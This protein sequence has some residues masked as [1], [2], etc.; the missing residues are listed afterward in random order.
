MVIDEHYGYFEGLFDWFVKKQGLSLHL[1]FVSDGDIAVTG[2]FI[3]SGFLVAEILESKYPSNSAK[4]FVHFVASR[5]LRIYP[6]YLFVFSIY[7]LLIEGNGISWDKIA[8]NSLLIPY[9]FLDLFS[10]DHLFNHIILTP[11]W[12]LSLDLVFYP[13]GY[14]FY[15]NRNF[16]LV[17]FSALLLYFCFI[18]FIA[19]ASSGT[20]LYS[21]DSWW[22]DR[23]YSTM[24][25]NL[26]AF[27]SGMLSRMYLKTLKIPTSLLCLSFLVM[28]YVCY[29][30]YGVSYFGSHFMGQASLLVM[31]TAFARNGYSKEESFLGS[32]TYSIYLIHLPVLLVV[33]HIVHLEGL[34]RLIPLGITLVLSLI[35]ARFIEEDIVERARKKWLNSWKPTGTEAVMRSGR[36]ST[37]ILAF[38]VFSMAF[39]S[40]YYLKIIHLQNCDEHRK[41]VHYN[42]HLCRQ[43]SA[44][45]SDHSLG[46]SLGNDIGNGKED[47]ERVRRTINDASTEDILVS[48]QKAK[49]FRRTSI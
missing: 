40:N 34:L 44:S 42:S 9:G 45:F 3:M 19:P 21:E 29:M 27:L 33:S 46:R 5:Y 47:Q 43:V 17:A 38:L 30:P 37:I 23:V 26:F 49:R 7:V 22:N 14:L 35:V 11:A 20:I 8:L 6:L 10:K 41:G 24:E 2:F 18:W 39:Y 1:S 31:I 36:Y 12:T 48:I 16:L 4:D 15:K 32:L 28:L 13:I 25:P